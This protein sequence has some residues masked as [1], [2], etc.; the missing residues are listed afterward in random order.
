MKTILAGMILVTMVLAGCG[1]PFAKAPTQ[2]APA[3]Q[4]W[5]PLKP[6]RQEAAGM[7][8]LIVGSVAAI[9]IGIAAAVNGSSSAMGWT[10]G[11]GVSLVLAVTLQRYGNMVALA[12]ALLVIGSMVLLVRS[13]WLEG[14]FW[15]L[16][17]HLDPR[18]E[19]REPSAEDAAGPAAAG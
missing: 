10:A 5:N 17:K 4:G 12:A 16:Q 14:G 8:W 15:S 3:Q 9:A 1:S 7:N 19:G 6:N 11:A 13:F 2:E 18:T